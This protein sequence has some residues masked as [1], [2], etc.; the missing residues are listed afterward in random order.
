MHIPSK[1]KL[2]NYTTKKNNFQKPN[3]FL[4][5]L[6]KTASRGYPYPI[7]FILSCLSYLK[8]P[9]HAILFIFILTKK[10]SPVD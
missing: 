7:N 6:F 8:Y 5:P 4:K 3:Q 10:S 2:L 1:F 9:I